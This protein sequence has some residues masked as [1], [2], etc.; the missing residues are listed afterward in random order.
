MRDVLIHLQAK[1]LR[2]MAEW[3]MRAFQASFPL[4]KEKIRFEEQG[5][6]KLMMEVLPRLYNY[7]AN[8]VGINQILNVFFSHL[9]EDS[10][11]VFN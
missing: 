9:I 4:V 5:E 7:R 11:S 10:E 6:R 8:N 1:S 2:Q 3:G